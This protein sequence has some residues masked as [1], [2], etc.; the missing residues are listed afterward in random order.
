[1]PTT[2]IESNGVDIGLIFG[3]KGASTAGATGIK[4]NGTDLNALLL[5]HADGNDI[6]YN[7]GIMV[8]GTD[9]RNIFA[10]PQ[11]SL[12]INGKR[13]SCTGLYAAASSGSVNFFFGL[14]STTAWQVQVSYA[15]ASSGTPAA[16]I[17]DSGAVPS[18]ATTV[19]YTMTWQNASGDTG[20][21][22]ATNGASSATALAANV[23][24][25]LNM[26]ANGTVNHQTT[27]TFTVVFRNSGGTAIS[28][29]TFTVELVN[30]GTA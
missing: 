20:S 7:T 19:Q 5:A 6:G 18:G 9:M 3:A 23:N 12:P 26:P 25:S 15:G 11:T 17:L 21:Y 2:G 14:S 28:T 1:M 10:S 16:G 27:Y 24:A 4:V 13:Y 8:N 29:T 30:E 22:T